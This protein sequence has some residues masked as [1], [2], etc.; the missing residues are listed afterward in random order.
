MTRIED[1]MAQTDRAFS[2]AAGQ[3][4]AVWR[5]AVPDSFGQAKETWAELVKA[6]QKMGPMSRDNEDVALIRL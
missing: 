5:G 1:D 2:D 4:S 3:L 6:G